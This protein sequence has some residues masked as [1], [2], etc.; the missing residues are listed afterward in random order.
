MLDGV[1]TRVDV[2]WRSP[3]GSALSIATCGKSRWL[4]NERSSRTA[5]LA[6]FWLNSHVEKTV[7]LITCCA[8]RSSF[9]PT[10]SSYTPSSFTPSSYSSSSPSPSPSPPP[11]STYTPTSS[12]P[13]SSP[14][15]SPSK[16]KRG[17]SYNEASLTSGFSSE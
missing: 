13:A 8:H 12:P 11:S 10:P 14:S 16:S 17:L 7:S 4:R 5:Q 1:A 15:P 9:S 3:M 6:L 2:R